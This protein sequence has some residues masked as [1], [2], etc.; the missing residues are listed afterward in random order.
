M[1]NNSANNFGNTYYGSVNNQPYQQ[2][3]SNYDACNCCA[4]LICL[5]CMCELCGGDF[6]SCI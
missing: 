5:D 2:Q 3:R 1:F 6:I 4:D